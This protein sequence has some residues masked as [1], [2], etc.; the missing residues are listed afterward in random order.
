MHE[1]HSTVG[2]PQVI[3][4]SSEGIPLNVIDSLLPSMY[5]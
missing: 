2:I 3:W 4:D 5:I 1:K